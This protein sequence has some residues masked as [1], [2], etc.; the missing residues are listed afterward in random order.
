LPLQLANKLQQRFPDVDFV[1]KDPNEN[2]WPTD[3]ELVI[4]DTASGIKQV[5][6]LT[7]LSKIETQ[8]SPC[9]LHDFDLALNLKLLEKIGQLKKITV[10]AIPQDIS[11]KTALDQLTKSIQ[12]YLQKH[13]RSS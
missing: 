1:I 8:G 11:E 2:L 9:S 13:T 4:I 5:H 6:T 7:D 12:I 10:F 3:G